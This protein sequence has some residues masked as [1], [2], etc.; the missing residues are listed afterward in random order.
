M[1]NGDITEGPLTYIDSDI[2]DT[3]WIQFDF[4]YP[5]LIDSARW[6][7]NL[8]GNPNATRGVW[9]WQG[10]HNGTYWTNIGS[11]F[12]LGGS[13]VQTQTTL[14]GNITAYRYYRIL[15]VSG[16]QFVFTTYLHEVEFKIS[17]NI[18]NYSPAYTNSGGMGYRIGPVAVTTDIPY[19]YGPGGFGSGEEISIMALID[20]SYEPNYDHSFW[21]W[22]PYGKPLAGCYVRFDF[23]YPVIISEATWW[24][25]NHSTADNGTW[26]W[27]G[28][29]DDGTWDNIGDTFELHGSGPGPGGPWTVHVP[30]G[31]KSG[32]VLSTL[33]DNITA[34]RYYRMLG[35]SGGLAVGWENEVDFQIGVSINPP[36]PM[37]EMMMRSHRLPGIR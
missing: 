2:D 22:G 30:G 17:Y 35:V 29:N 31:Y 37:Y 18:F 26:Q 3:K 7:L 9:R 19:L 20:G 36:L 11:S 8:E 4:L 14:H 34:Y 23:G 16:S 28:S 5:A 10:S 25:G 15:G 27:Q 12:T 6:Y 32:L 21:W 33:N 13:L 24:Q 1:V